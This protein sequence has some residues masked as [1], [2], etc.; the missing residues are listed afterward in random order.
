MD[1]NSSVEKTCLGKNVIEISIE[2]AEGHEDWFF[3]EYQDTANSGGK[4]EPKAIIF[5]KMDTEEVSDRYVAPC[6]VNGLEAYDGEINLGTEENMISNEFAMKLIE[7]ASRKERAPETYDYRSQYDAYEYDRYHANYNIEMEDDTMYREFT[8]HSTNTMEWSAFGS[9][10][11]K[12]DADDQN[13]SFEDLISPI[14]EHD[15]ES[16]PFKVR[17]GVM[18]ANTTPYLSTLEEPILSP[19]DDIRSKEDEEFLSLSLY[20]DQ[21]S[22]LLDEAEV[23]HIQK[24]PQLPRVAINHVGENDSVFE[25]KKEQE[26]VSLVKDENHVVKRCHENSLSKLTYI[27]VKQVHRKARVGIRKQILSLCHGKREFQEVLNSR[28]LINFAS[29]KPQ[30]KHVRIASNRRKRKIRVKENVLSNHHD[31]EHLSL[32]RADDGKLSASREATRDD[33]DFGYIPDIKGIKTPPFVRKM[34]KNSSNTRKQL[35]KYQ[36]IYSDIGPSLSTGKPLTQKEAKKEA[37]AINV[38]RRYSILEEERPVMIKVKG[39]SLIE[40]GDPRAFVIPIRLKAKINLNALADTGS[41]INVMPYHVYKELGRKEVKDV[42]KGITM[43]N[44]SKAEPMGFLKD[45]LCQG[46]AQNDHLWLVSEN[47]RY[48]KIQKNDL[49]L[50]SMFDVRHQNGYV[51]VA[52]LIARWMMRKGAGSQKESMIYYKQFIMSIVK[53]KNLLSEE[54]LNSLNALIYCRALD[55]TT[56]RELINSEGRQIPKVPEPGVSRV[57]IP[58]PQRESMQDLYERMRSMEIR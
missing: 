22:N 53:R 3:S 9:C 7:I 42:K 12:V 10:K 34:G 31:N 41:D 51:N 23:T 5:L 26:K 55:I 36:L 33:L 17:E 20:K 44:Q 48:D 37:L 13:N 30:K 32:C 40:K 47:T 15:K 45:V 56:L 49:W 19:I 43:L 21:C 27:I 38:C 54:V 16:V 2:K 18:E 11:D 52:L 28:K 46:V 35:E 39:E 4:K 8:L 57:A 1:P 14:K 50:L 25:N 24:P 58:R 6:F 29:K